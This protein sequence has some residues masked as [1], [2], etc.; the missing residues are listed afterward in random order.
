LKKRARQ[1]GLEVVEKSLP[2]STAEAESPKAQ[3][4]DQS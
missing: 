1:L 4:T 2:K 3:Q